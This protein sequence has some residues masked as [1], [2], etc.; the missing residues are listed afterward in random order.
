MGK[1]K[2]MIPEQIGF[3][4]GGRGRGMKIHRKPK[5]ISIKKRFQQER[6]I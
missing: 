6:S 4:E 2:N 3:A 5:Q 1:R